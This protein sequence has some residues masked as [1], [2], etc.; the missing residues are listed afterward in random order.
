M[1]MGAGLEGQ[2]GYQCL[3][4]AGVE[5]WEAYSR[6]FH[7]HLSCPFSGTQRLQRTKGGSVS[8]LKRLSVQHIHSLREDL[9][10]LSSGPL[11]I[12]CG[13]KMENETDK[14]PCP[15]GA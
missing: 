9:E 2:V 14:N 11:S 13:E 15:R 12:R 6:P 1:G 8:A 3:Y 10:W 7:K 4:M 5:L